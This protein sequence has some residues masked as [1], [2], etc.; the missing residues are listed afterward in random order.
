M[1]SIEGLVYLGW[2]RIRTAARTRAGAM[3]T[4]IGMRRK[5]KRQAK[6][7][8]MENSAT[9]FT[10]RLNSWPQKGQISSKLEASR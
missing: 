2:M 8:P 1:S 3:V 9:C 4:R 6:N 7:N 10:V 5:V